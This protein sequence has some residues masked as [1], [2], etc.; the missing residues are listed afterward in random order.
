MRFALQNSDGVTAVSKFLR[1]KTLSTYQ[2][3]CDIEAIPNFIDT[4]VYAPRESCKYR[5]LFAPEGEKV[6]VHTSNF[7]PV[8]RVPDVIRTF[9]EVLKKIPVKLLLIGDGP[10]RSEC[11]TLSRELGIFEHVRF[12]GKQDA[13]VDILAAC[14]LF[15]LPSQS[16]SF[17]LSAL[18]AMSCGLP[19][20]STSIGGIPEVNL[21]AETGYIAE[22][23]DIDRMAR[24][25]IELLT[26]EAKYAMF[27]AAARR[28]AVEVYEK[29]KIVP[30]YEAFYEKILAQP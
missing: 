23:G 9:A 8:K 24:Y 17:G 13:L 28:R 11:E 4:E 7:R 21:H 18:E 3:D 2:L 25:A 5:E 14:D 26:N 30:L 6:M 1:D 15:V 20:I 29:S 10:D 27:S 16:E 22:I 19:V 12:L